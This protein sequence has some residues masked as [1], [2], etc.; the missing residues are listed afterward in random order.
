MDAA[1]VA[2]SQHI[3]GGTHVWLCAQNMTDALDV[4][5]VAV[6]VSILMNVLD[7]SVWQ[8]GYAAFVALALLI[9]MIPIQ[10]KIV[11]MATVLLKKSLSSTDERVRVTGEVLGAMDI[12][13][14]YAWE[15]SFRERIDGMRDTELY[16][17]QR[18]AILRAF[19]FFLISTIPILVCGDPV[20]VDH[21]ASVGNPIFSNDC[22][23]SWSLHTPPSNIGEHSRSPRPPPRTAIG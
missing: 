19:N 12:V 3:T 13:K 23:E 20:A 15:K 6:C 16:W 1:S 9:I 2:V 18:S 14:C 8:V 7:V 5:G 21:V 10:K 22:G 4:L 11:T 17:I